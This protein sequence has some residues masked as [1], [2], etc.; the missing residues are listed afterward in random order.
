MLD[1]FS[2]TELLLGEE[3]RY[4]AVCDNTIRASGIPMTFTAWKQLLA[5]KS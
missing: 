2:R 3:A 1:R 4:T 5:N